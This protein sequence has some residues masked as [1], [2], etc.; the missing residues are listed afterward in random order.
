MLYRVCWK[1]G[2]TTENLDYVDSMDLVNQRPYEWA[3]VQPM[4]YGAD[5]NPDNAKV[6]ET[7]WGKK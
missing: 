7:A 6:K 3:A 4:N 2:S 5:C 1:D